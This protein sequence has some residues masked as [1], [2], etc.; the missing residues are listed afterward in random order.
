MRLCGRDKFFDLVANRQKLSSEQPHRPAGDEDAAEK[1]REAVKAVP[2]HITRGL[3]VCDT[4]DYGGAESEDERGAEV[5]ECNRQCVSSYCFF[6]IA[7]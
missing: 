1:H 6:P 5:I 3:A 7:M 2:D 4:E